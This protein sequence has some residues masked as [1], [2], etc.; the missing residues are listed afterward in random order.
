MPMLIGPTPDWKPGL[1]VTFICFSVS[2]NTDDDIEPFT[3]LKI[4]T[5]E[6]AFKFADES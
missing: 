5:E 2:I 4:L 3:T 6:V 1:I